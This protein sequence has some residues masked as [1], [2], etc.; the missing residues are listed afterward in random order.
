[1]QLQIK[2]VRGRAVRL[3]AIV[4]AL[5]IILY[6]L[7]RPLSQVAGLAASAAALAFIAFPAAR[8]FEKKLSRP[9]AALAALAAIVIVAAGLIWLLLPAILKDV[10]QLARSA[11]GLV[12]R[13]SQ[14]YEGFSIWLETRLPGLALPRPNL[15]QL[16]GVLSN[17]ASGT[18][19]LAGSA[20]DGLSRLSLAVM[21]GYFFL[22]D[23]ERMLLRLELL[24]P[25]AYRQTAVRIG[26]AVT[27]ELR[28]YLK[29]QL[30]IAGMVGLL[31]AV[32]LMLA[33]VKSAL[34]LGISVGILN[35]IPYFGP[36]IGGV[37]AVLIA[38]ADG[39]KRA[40]L[41]AGVLVAVQQLDSAV[42]SPRIMGSLTGFSPATV[43]IA[44][45]G[46]ARLSG[47]VGMLCALPAIMSIRTVFRV[48]VQRH[49][50]I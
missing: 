24:V 28:L 22:C 27:Q 20:T 40:A 33:G 42:I 26:R 1:M 37:P 10:G 15:D 6:A 17:L 49:E 9:A 23:R 25:S 11:P 34:V 14:W 16:S 32:G 50:N 48:F 44:I 18:I 39:W 29:G 13:V 5:A 4:A 3:T 7:R 41:A 21:L 46:G 43:L 36:F 38:L 2:P 8:L 47:I 12:R 31:S 30:M 35:M 19:A 45:Y